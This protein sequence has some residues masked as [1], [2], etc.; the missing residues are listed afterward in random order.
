MG[1]LLLE[2]LIERAKAQHYHV[3]IGGIDGDNA[4]SIKMHRSSVS[5][6]AARFARPASN[7]AGGSICT[8][9]S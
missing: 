5:P 4:V 1:R 3:L 9:I 7:S 8:S 2:A 6:S